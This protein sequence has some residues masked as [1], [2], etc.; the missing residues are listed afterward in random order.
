MVV[1]PNRKFQSRRCL[2]A[3]NIIKEGSSTAILRIDDDLIA[4]CK[5]ETMSLKAPRHPQNL[6]VF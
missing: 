1:T 6:K 5:I 2:I 3:D 4:F